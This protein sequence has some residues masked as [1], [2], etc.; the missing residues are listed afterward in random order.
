MEWGGGGRLCQAGFLTPVA[1]A[2]SV[3]V[4]DPVQC[5]LHCL[6]H[7]EVESPGPA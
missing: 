4:L 7:P 2:V 5:I 3:V 1:V 6:S